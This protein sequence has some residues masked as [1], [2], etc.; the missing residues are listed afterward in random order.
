MT[1]FHL[2][3]EAEPFYQTEHDPKKFIEL[4]LKKYQSLYY[5]RKVKEIKKLLSKH[6]QDLRGKNV[7]DV[8]CC[9]G[10]FSVLFA[11]QGAHVTGIDLSKNAIAAAVYYAKQQ[12]V[13]CSFLCGELSVIPA[14]KKFDLILAKDV[15]EHVQD[16]VAFI[17][18]LSSKLSP[19][20]QLVITTQNWFCLNYFFE[21]TLRKIFYPK[22]KW[23]GWD[24]THVRWYSCRG[25]EKKLEAAG[26]QAM[27][28]SG[29]YYLPYEMIKVLKLEP[30]W[31]WFVLLDDFLGDK[32]P[33]NRMGWSISV[34]GEKK[35]AE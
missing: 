31:R 30:R 2:S 23:V 35:R 25:L 16:D 9:G 24:P 28:Y 1:A 32:W 15:I 17:E 22:K 12:G 20:G 18:Q 13:S 11:K 33:L 21:G 34:M 5:S 3:Q 4:Y 6:C 29:S 27:G 19:G 10:Y 7:L 8:G 26:L 14:A